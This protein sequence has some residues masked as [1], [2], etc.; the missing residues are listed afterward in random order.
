MEDN[1]PDLVK[2]ERANA[3]MELQESISLEINESRVGQEMKVLIDRVEG[4]SF[5]GRTDFD[6]PEVDNEVL[7]SAKEHYLRVGDF[8]QVKITGASE[9][10]LTA[11][12]V[13]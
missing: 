2:Q 9:F 13:K 12:P 7:I 10:D 5:V 6:S 4:G 3:V 8:A 11:T 1:V